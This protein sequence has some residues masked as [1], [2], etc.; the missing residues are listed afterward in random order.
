MQRQL[1]Y[2]GI[3]PILLCVRACVRLCLHSTNAVF[4][5]VLDHSQ[6]EDIGNLSVHRKTGGQ[7]VPILKHTQQTIILMSS[8]ADK[9]THRGTGHRFKH[10]STI[11]LKH[12]LYLP[13]HLASVVLL[14]FSVPHSPILI[15]P[16]PTFSFQSF[17]VSTPSPPQPSQ[18]HLLAS[19]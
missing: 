7:D 4:P 6:T 3:R 11:P 9:F 13:V 10:F 8:F 1:I 5:E 16:G 18:G 15:S 17:L 12:L 19:N 14:P 2:K